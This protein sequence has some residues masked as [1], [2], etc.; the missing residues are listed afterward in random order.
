MRIA[1]YGIARSP[2]STLAVRPRSNS[3]Q[4]ATTVAPESTTTSK[5]YLNL[6]DMR[7]IDNRWG[8]DALN[9][10][11]NATYKVYVNTDKTIGY[12]FNR[13]K[14]DNNP[15]AQQK[16]HPDYP[17]IEFGVAPFGS[18]SSNLTSP[19]CS[20]TTLLPIQIKNLTSA[21]VTMDNFNTTYQ[22]TTNYDT[23]FEFW[24]SKNNPAAPGVTD[25]G[26]FAEIIVFL[27][28]DASR[29]A[30]GCDKTG[31]V[32]VGGLTY[33][34]CHQSDS[35]ANGQW[36]FYNFYLSAAQNPFSGKGDV[37]GILD[38]VM[39]TYTGGITSDMWLTRIEVGSEIDDNTQGTVKI[40][41]LTFEVNGTS[42][43][44]Q[45]AP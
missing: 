19:A 16:G 37:K 2:T 29:T 18:G 7:L 42:K 15:P 35:W 25:G 36:R 28:W 9:C 21:S 43:P 24:I 23:N 33:N 14:C 12:D 4:A 17:E 26:V 31:N 11:S 10:G 39:K 3:V 6:G 30:G 20:S 40:N 41:N 5:A 45:L 34:L 38:W 8:A 22:K 1:T 44:I 13:G 32:S 27:S